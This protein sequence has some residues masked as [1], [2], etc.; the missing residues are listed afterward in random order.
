MQINKEKLENLY[1]IVMAMIISA[2]VTFSVTSVIL[3]K[4]GGIQYI[5]VTKS[6]TTGLGTLLSSFKLL[7]NEKYLYDMDETKMTEAAIKAYIDAVGDEYTVYYTPEEMET[8]KTYT[9]GNYLGIGIY[10]YS[11]MENNKIIV[12][13]P[14]KGGPADKAGIKPGDVI[15]KVDGKTYN[16][17]EITDM[18]NYMK[19]GKEGSTLEIEIIRNNETYNFTVERKIVN[20]YPIEGIVLENN[21]G[22]IPLYSFDENCAE[23]F[24]NAYNDLKEKG[25]KSLII[26]LRDNGGGIVDETMKIAD[27]ILDKD[28]EML[29]TVDKNN[30]EEITKAKNNPIIN[31][32]IVV[33]VNENTASASE[34]LTGALKDYKKAIII[35]KTT[36]GK[37]V[38]QELFSLKDGSGIKITTSEYY[39]PNRDRI[40]KTGVIPDYEVDY[41]GEGILDEQLKKAIEILSKIDN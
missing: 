20:L 3:Y 7:L 22:Y 24:K 10:I 28:S 27:Y 9:T 36:Y 23:K 26:D 2:L 13:A 33:L 41:T 21:I 6:D 15:T 8:M 29:I 30:N 16:A 25:I 12:S 34:M 38:I 19:N 5:A 35:G 17:S 39:T 14:M 31:M 40:N 37:G 32:P 11:D 1:R 4:T 18:T